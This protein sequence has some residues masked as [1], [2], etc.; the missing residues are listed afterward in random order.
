M[1]KRKNS[2]TAA[3]KGH[4][5][6]NKVLTDEKRRVLFLSATYAGSVHDNA[7]VDRE[8]GQFPTGIVLHQDV[9]FKGHNPEG[10]VVIQPHKK[11]RTSALTEQ[12][13]QENKQRASLRVKVEHGIGAVKV[14]RILKD[15][16]RMY[17]PDIK[18]LV[19]QLG[20]GLNNFK[21]T[22]KT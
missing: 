16:I 14:F 4:K 17:K 11:P 9:G 8:G 12:Q 19:R 20:C 21:R 10:I 2:I 1:K 15:R 3:K 6:K 7:L 18:D 13:K 5:V 22:Y